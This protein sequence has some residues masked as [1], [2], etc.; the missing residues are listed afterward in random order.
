MAEPYTNSPMSFSRYAP[1]YDRMAELNP[2]YQANLQLF[3]R[4]LDEQNFDSNIKVADVGAGTGNYICEM[5]SFF[6]EASY[7]HIDSDPEMNRIARDKYVSRGF[8]NVEIV[9]EYVQRLDIPAGEFDIL[10]CV[11]SLYA[12][13]P[14]SLVLK[15]LHSWLKPGG[16]L[17]MIDFGRRQNVADWAFY[18]LGEVAKRYGYIR[19]A[20][21][22]LHFAKVSRENVN[23]TRGQDSGAYWTHSTEQFEEVLLDTGFSVGEVAQCYRGYSDLAICRK[24][25]EAE[26]NQPIA[27]A[28]GGS[29]SNL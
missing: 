15:K 8:E 4:V 21:E 16:A 20:R 14:Q 19:A 9:E 7:F 11:H 6:P 18:I 22:F 1:E 2:A 28:N 24:P 26:D 25:E 5:Q 3:R 29:H 12:M 13:N 17:F 23:T 10:I 27:V